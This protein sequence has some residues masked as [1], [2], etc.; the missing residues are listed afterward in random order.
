M[1]Q[2]GVQPEPPGAGGVAQAGRL[3]TDSGT[4]PR[5]ERRLGSHVTSN[6]QR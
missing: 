1:I 5:G 2:A 3:P 4:S 6:Q